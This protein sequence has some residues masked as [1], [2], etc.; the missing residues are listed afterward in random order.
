M[1]KMQNIPLNKKIILFDG[2]CNL[3]SASVQ[4]IIRH[5]RKGNLKFASLQSEIGQSLLAQFQ[6]PLEVRTI[7]FIINGKALLRSN[8]ALE[9]CKELN[10]LYPYFRYLKFIPT[11]VRDWIYNI[12]AKNRY[13]WFGKKDQC[14]IPTAE[15]TNRF[16]S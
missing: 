16:I 4:F 7:V 14:W 15:L 5:N 8:A 11:S 6:L 1:E 3:C 9:I 12:I 13:R 2:V 10:G